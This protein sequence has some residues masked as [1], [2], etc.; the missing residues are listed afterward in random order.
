M[1]SDGAKTSVRAVL[2]RGK[3]C[4]GVHKLARFR[5]SGARI[6]LGCSQQAFKAISTVMK[7]PVPK[8]WRDEHVKGSGSCRRCR[9]IGERSE[10]SACKDRIKASKPIRLSTG[11][12]NLPITVRNA[13][14]GWPTARQHPENKWSEGYLMELAVH[15]TRLNASIYKMRIKGIP[16]WFW[17]RFYL[18][19]MS[20]Y[21]FQHIWILKK[22]LRNSMLGLIYISGSTF[23][24]NPAEAEHMNKEEVNGGLNPVASSVKGGDL[25]SFIRLSA[26]FQTDTTIRS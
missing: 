14:S 18:M 23:P 15:F 4:V 1:S 10:P 7:D 22:R 9:S 8:F 25:H 2:R 26:H 12:L 11:K 13:A 6:L 24:A 3:W 5:V 17:T 19:D 21:S 16:Y 20:G